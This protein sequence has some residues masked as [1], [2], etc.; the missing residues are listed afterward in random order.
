[1]HAYITNSSPS[2]SPNHW[3]ATVCEGVWSMIGPLQGQGLL[4]FWWLWRTLWGPYPSKSAKVIFREFEINQIPWSCNLDL[5]KGSK[6]SI[7]TFLV[8]FSKSYAT[9]ENLHESNFVGN[10]ILYRIAPH[11]LGAIF[12]NEG[13]KGVKVV[14]FYESAPFLAKFQTF[15]KINYIIFLVI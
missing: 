3:P 9:T 1:M 5:E 12:D 10:S 8:I 13:A 4:N 2:N 6:R 15:P 7:F 11:Q 14:N